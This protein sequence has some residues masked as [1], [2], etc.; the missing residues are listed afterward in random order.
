M[1]CHVNDDDDENILKSSLNIFFMNEIDKV[2]F[3]AG[4]RWGKNP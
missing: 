1:S 3:A 2:T 4:L